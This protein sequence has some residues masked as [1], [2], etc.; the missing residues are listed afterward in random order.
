M[1]SMTGYSRVEYSEKG[2]KA[3]VELKSLNG[4]FLDF[5]LRI[6]KSISHKEL[7]IREII[8]SVVA[9]GNVTVQISTEW[10]P[11][12]KPFQLNEKAAESIY[13]SLVT[14]SKKL[15]IRQPVTLSDILTFP[16]YLLISDNLTQDDDTE[17]TVVRKALQNA[18]K[19]LG[20]RRSEEG[21]NT[22][23]DISQRVKKLE[24][25]LNKIIE[26]SE[27]RVE[28][29]REKLRLKVAQ[30]FEN[31]EIDEQRIQME[32]LILANKLDINEECSRLLSHIQ[33]TKE[34]LR[35]KEPIGQKLIFILQEMNREFN[36]LASKADDAVISQIVVKSKDEI[37][38]IR[39]QAQ[40]IE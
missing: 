17:W 8:K 20:K 5:S 22:Y 12:I 23:K 34:I 25:Y 40:N 38:K 39:E 10:D 3:V 14:L 30:L 6:P 32:I 24:E 7:Q 35:S 21:K 37:E 31:E 13:S 9:R 29:E 16:N 1:K 19:E 4:R 2:V 28:K 26:L 27:G 18:V 33:F 15:K 11:T 36:T